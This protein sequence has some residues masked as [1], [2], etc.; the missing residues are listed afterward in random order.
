MSTFF[1][2]GVY[3]FIGTLSHKNLT[4]MLPYAY[5]W[6]HAFLLTKNK[7]SM[8]VLGCYRRNSWASCCCIPLNCESTC[9]IFFVYVCTREYRYTLP[10]TSH[11]TSFLSLVGYTTEPG[12]AALSVW[13]NGCLRVQ[14]R[15]RWKC[16]TFAWT[17]QLL[18][19]QPSPAR[20]TNMVS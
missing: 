2:S 15:C 18:L 16:T 10:Q 4:W 13:R 8:C 11:Q 12:C 6:L 14:N 20:E 3:I 1:C 19:W 9:P 5:Q 17:G 7:T